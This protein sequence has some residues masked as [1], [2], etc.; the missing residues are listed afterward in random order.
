MSNHANLVARARSQHF[1]LLTLVGLAG[2]AGADD[3]VVT[4]STGAVTATGAREKVDLLFMV[5]NSSSM[6]PAQQKLIHEL[7]SFAAALEALPGGLPDLHVAV[8]SSD[9]GAP[10]DVAGPLG[11]S[12]FG[13]MGTFHAA[14]SG[15]CAAT[16]LEPGAMF[17]SNS[18][19]VANYTGELSDVLTCI[20]ALGSSGCGFENQ[21]GSVARALGA[22]GQ[23]PPAANAGFLR[24]D[25]ELAIILLSNEDDCSA[26]PDT[27]L[28]SLNG[29]AQSLSNPLGP[30]ANYRCNRYGHL[31]K[32]ANPNAL[33]QPPEEVPADATGSPPSLTLT[34]CVSD[35]GCSG[36]LTPVQSFVNGIKALKR[37]AGQVV[38]GAI[39]APPEPYTVTWVPP[40][41]PPPNAAGQL[42][43][44]VMHSC[45]P[46]GGDDVNPAGQQSEDGTFGDPAVRI[47]QWARAF[48]DDGFVSSICDPSYGA[49]MQQF[50]SLIASHLQPSGVPTPAPTGPLATSATCAG[51]TGHPLHKVGCSVA[52]TGQPR[53][54]A[55]ALAGLGLVMVRARRRGRR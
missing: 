26:P 4:T 32:G 38:V 20:A 12:E 46:V 37:D 10:G 47:A 16:G 17:I 54:F 36:M 15:D 55:I 7:Q 19:G 18:G 45:G 30:I 41:A 14:P 13:D 44:Q 8:V 22:D 42:W 3:P 27:T 31:C 33:V 50:A 5:D 23:P 21:L 51:P 2:C 53:W 43:P 6:A 24:D 9:M 39:V 34:E 49:P 40:V 25:A 28:F 35:D 52:A 48:G 11:C 29:G 1:V